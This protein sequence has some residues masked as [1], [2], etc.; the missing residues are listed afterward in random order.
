MI[1]FY[2]LG[3][4]KNF[5]KIRFLIIYGN[6]FIFY[7]QTKNVGGANKN[8]GGAIKIVGGAI[9]IVGSASKNVGG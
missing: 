9:K 2:T 6:F 5:W 1:L 8:V 7:L 4:Y 3:Q